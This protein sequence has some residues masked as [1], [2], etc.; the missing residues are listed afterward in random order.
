MS[1][2]LVLQGHSLTTN[3]VEA[4]LA[5]VRGRGAARIPA[6]HPAWRLTGADRAAQAGLADYCTPRSIDF[7]FI[8][9][10]RRWDGIGLVAMDMDSTLITIECIDEIADHVGRKAEVARVTERA[11]QGEIDWPQSLAQRVALLEGIDEAALDEVYARRLQLTPGAAQLI[12]Y[13]KLHGIRLLLVSGGFTFFT[14][15]LKAR[16]G[17][18]HAYANELEIAGGKLTGRVIGPLCDAPAKARHLVETRTAL[19]LAAHQAIA[20]GDGAN[21]LLMMDAAGYSIAFRAKPKVRARASAA[22]NFGGLDW[23]IPLFSS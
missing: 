16:L 2:D 11:M 1:F 9:E 4:V 8:P 10:Y 18:D 21:D 15:R 20:I 6:P 23:A 5:T 12:G 7:A 17:I 3:D 13:A 19:G 22:I 14:E